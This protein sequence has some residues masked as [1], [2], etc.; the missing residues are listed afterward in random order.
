M[1][2]R[3]E[4]EIGKS[5]AEIACRQHRATSSNREREILKQSAHEI[6]IRISLSS[7]DAKIESG[8]PRMSSA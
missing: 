4:I 8:A 1:L 5:A 2:A 6:E 7:R 3:C